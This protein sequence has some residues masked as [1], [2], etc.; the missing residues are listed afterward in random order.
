MAVLMLMGCAGSGQTIPVKID[1]STVPP[2]AKVR[3]APR[4]A[5]MPFDD[6]RPDKSAIGLHQHYLES[7]VDRY[8]PAEG[9]AADQVTKFVAEY[10]KQAGFPVTVLSQGAQPAAGTAD[11]V[12][13]G[14]I[15]SYWM[16]AVARLARTELVARN[17][18]RLKVTNTADNSTVFSTV[19]GE[20]TSKVVSFDLSDI[21][22]LDGEALGQSL[23]RFLSDTTLVNGALKP[24]REG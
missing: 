22:Q 21:E 23:A 11:M 2:P 5:I 20:G 8:V 7:I 4:I 17:R 14:Y 24:K 16:E 6:I 15:E 9:T 18:L 3:S 1:M 19:A 10:L 12:L 13:S